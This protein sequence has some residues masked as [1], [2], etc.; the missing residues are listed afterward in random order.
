MN[1]R[2]QLNNEEHCICYNDDLDV[3]DDDDNYENW[4]DEIYND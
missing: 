3:D 2:S 1:V 4:E